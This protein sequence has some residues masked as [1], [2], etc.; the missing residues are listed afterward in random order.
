MKDRMEV[1]PLSRGVMLLRGSTPIRP[2]TGRL[3]LFPSSLTRNPISSPCGLPSLSSGR[4]LQAYH[5]PLTYLMD[6]LGAVSPP[7]GRHLRQ[8]SGESLNLPTCLPWH[9]RTRASV[10]SSLSA[11]LACRF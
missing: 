9:L 4:W 8:E 2:I 3:S 7:V 11:S 5:V 1:C 10:G 6:G